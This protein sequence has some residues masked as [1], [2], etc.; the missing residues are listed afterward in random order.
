MKKVIYLLLATL[1]VASCTQEEIIDGPK[2]KGKLNI[3]LTSATP[4]TRTGGSDLP[5]SE[6]NIQRVVVGIFDQ[7][8]DVNTIEEFP[9]AKLNGSTAEGIICNA[10]NQQDI[11]VVANAPENHF[12]GITTKAAFI[13]KTVTLEETTMAAGYAAGA[14]QLS[15]GLPMSGITT[16]DIIAP[17]TST[18]Q[19]VSLKISRLV[20]RV[21]LESVKMELE[22][23]CTFKLLS[24]ELRNVATT[25]DV[26]PST[27]V[28]PTTSVFKN[29]GDQ[30]D[31]AWLKHSGI[32]KDEDLG[33]DK[34]GTELLLNAQQ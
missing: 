11:I 21:S 22:S 6:A 9:A 15:T 17:T 4:N 23:G 20:S 3:T 12:K 5:T 34:N 7:T 27:S 16:E 24:V 33:S 25:S 26:Q 2:G 8:G 18:P 13:A 28:E 14:Y 31:Y 1:M 19:A 30:L 10:G 32:G 29:L